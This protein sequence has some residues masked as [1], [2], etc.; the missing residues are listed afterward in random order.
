M[1]IACP[2][3]PSGNTCRAGTTTVYSFGDD[4]S[5]LGEYAW[6]DENT[7][8]IGEQHAHRVGQKLPNPWSLYDMHG[9]VNEWCQ[10]WYGPYSSEKVVS[11]P[12]GPVQ[13]GGRSRRGGASDNHMTWVRSTTR[14][15]LVGGGA[16]SN[17][18]FRVVRVISQ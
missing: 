18:G 11:D 5:K 1:N 17:T 8:N 4:A 10:D 13:G 7:W 16:A 2:P 6:Y 3:K 9:N 14:A 15:S 12:M